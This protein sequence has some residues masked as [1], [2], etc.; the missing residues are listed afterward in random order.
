M[1]VRFDAHWRYRGL[2]AL[3]LEN[4]MVRVVILPELGAKVW[5]IVYKPLDQEMLWHNPRIYPRLVPFGAAYDDVFCGGWDELFPNDSPVEVNGD[6]Y[7]DHGEMW[8]MPF[9]WE[10]VEATP[11][12]ITVRLYRQGVVTVTTM[13]KRITL[14]AGE[15]MIH[16]HHRI[17][18]TGPF[19][20]DFLWKLHPA[21]RI[22]ERSRIDLPAHRVM[23]GDGVR[24]RIGD[25]TEF[26]WPFV[27]TPQGSMDMRKIPAQTAA[28]ADFYYATELDEGWCALSDADGGAGFGLVFDRDVLPTVWVFGAY[29]GWRGLYTAILE[30]CTGYPYRLD[31]AIA[32]G[33][34]GHLEAG[35]TLE[36]EITAVL[37]HGHTSVRRL[38]HD[39]IVES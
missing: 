38:T 2:E 39:G 26:T 32:H 37:Y 33:R 12:E 25:V 31:E 3:V 8:S 4:E 21:L 16:F 9:D 15:S 17:V 19:A 36:T 14:R 35:E 20:L 28:T 6:P 22:T 10:I 30:P 29:G 13:E 23:A 5:S 1:G 11:E 34:T 24:S 7:P 27:S 18:N